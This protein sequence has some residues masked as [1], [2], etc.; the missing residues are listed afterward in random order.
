MNRKLWENLASLYSVQALNYLVP[1]FTL[2]YLTRVLGTA[3]WGILAF[4]DAYANY[5]SLVVEYGFGLSAT[6]EIAQLRHDRE[7]RSRQFAGVMGAQIILAGMAA[8][9]TL[10]LSLTVPTLVVYRPTLAVWL[11]R[12]RLAERWFRFGISRD[13]SACGWWHSLISPQIQLPRPPY[14]FL[15]AGLETTGCRWR[16]A[17]E[18]PCSPWE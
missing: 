12:W 18:R 10:I 9:L 6:R 1:L 2:P 17:P 3:P 14:C 7:A 8:A 16:S 4:A 15:F 13:W 5:L 11:C